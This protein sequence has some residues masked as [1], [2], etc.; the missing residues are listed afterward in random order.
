MARTTVARASRQKLAE[1]DPILIAVC[2][3]ATAEMEKNSV[4]NNAGIMF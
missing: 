1:L 2:V 4:V 3:A